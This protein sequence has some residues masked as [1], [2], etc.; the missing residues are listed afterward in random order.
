MD[1]TAVVHNE[2]KCFSRTDLP[3]AQQLSNFPEPWET[4]VRWFLGY[5]AGKQVRLVCTRHA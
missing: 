2:T 4:D 5:R 1:K 3:P